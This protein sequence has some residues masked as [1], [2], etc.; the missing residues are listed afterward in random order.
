MAQQTHEGPSWDELARA[1]GRGRYFTLHPLP[2]ANASRILFRVAYLGDFVSGKWFTVHA[3]T[4]AGASLD[5]RG[6]GGSLP[7]NLCV[8]YIPAPS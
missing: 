2:G 7:M 3:F 4:N 8:Y 6:W 5:L 1:I